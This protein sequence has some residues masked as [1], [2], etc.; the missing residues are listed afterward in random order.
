M[1][2][3]FKFHSDAKIGSCLLSNSA[4][5]VSV[6]NATLGYPQFHKIASYTHSHNAD[7]GIHLISTF[8]FE[9]MLKVLDIS[10]LWYII[11]NVKNF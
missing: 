6:E 1:G 2:W 9:K 7:D 5:F 4:H 11:E 10:C 3:H 8:I